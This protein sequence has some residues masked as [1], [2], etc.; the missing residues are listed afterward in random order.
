M[1]N[2]R[3]ASS[4]VEL[5]RSRAGE[6][7]A[8][9]AYTFLLNGEEE[10]GHATYGEL[11]RRARSIAARLQAHSAPGA[12]ALL[13]YP[14]GLEYIAALFGCFYAGVTAVPAYPP[15][16]NRA[17]ARLQSIVADCRPTL[18]LTTRELLGD[19]ERLC[20]HTPELAGLR[21]VATED[22]PAEEAEGWRD[23]EARGDTLAFLQ[24]TSGSTAAPKG[25]MVSHGNLLHNF[26][27][28]EE[29]CG[30]TPQTRSVIW[31]PPYHDMGLIGGILQPLFTG[32]WAALFSPVAFIQRPAR[33][34]EAVSRYR[35]T[36]SGGPNFAY[37]LCV[38]AVGPEERAGLDLSHWEIAFNGA[39][40][41][42][43]ET[44]R[45]FAESFAPCGFRE[46]AFYP[47]YGLAEATLMVT[48]SRP[49][50]P[51][52]QRAVEPEAL[53]EGLVRAA[54]EE[55]S[56]RLVGSGRSAPSQRV[57][58]VDPATLR[59]CPSER[60][61]EVWVAGPSVAR[62]YWGRPE[63]TA[64]TF[65]A[66]EAGTGEGP[67][68]RTGDL[69][70]LDGG[71]LYITGRLKD[72]IVIRGRNHYPQDIEQTALRSHEG[73]RAGSGAAF[74]I[75]EGG[76]ERLVVVQEVTRRAARLDVEEVA[77]AIRR[78][79]AAEHGLQ[80]H[81]VAVVRPGGVPKT[82]SGKVQRRA[83]RALF[84]AGDLPLVGV[85]V[86]EETGREAPRPVRA[87]LTREALEAAEVGERQALLE[88][89]L[90]ER[91]AQ[92][93]GVDPARVDREQPLVAL[94][95]DSLRAMEL[96]GALEAS[97][98]AQVPVSSLLD[99]T[100][101]DRLAAELLQ[102][103]FLADAA[104]PASGAAAG[105]ER[106]LSFAQERL[107][108]LDRLR[109]GATYNISL[110]VRVSGA[111]DPDV[112]GRVLGEIVR[113]HESLRTVFASVDGRPVQVVRP[114]GEWALAV[115]DVSGLPA[116]ERE[117]A[118]RRIAEAEAGAPFDL[119]AGPLLRTR[120]VRLAEDD[121]LL[122]VVMHHTVSDGGSVAVL[123]R[124][125]AA[126]YPALLAGRG[127]PLPPLPVQYGDWALRQR[128]RVRGAAL[129][130][131]LAYWRER[132]RG[133][134]PLP[135]P[136]DHPR[137]AVQSFR[138]AT[139]RFEIPAEVMEG[140]RALARAEGA[141]LFMALL[142][143]W[144]LV[145]ARYSGESDVAVGT[146]VSGRDR[147]E[148]AGLV[149]MFVDTLVLRVEVAPEEG[150]RELLA[151]ARAAALEGFRHRDLPFERLVEDLHP[152]RDLSR[153]PLF[154]VMLAP[155]STPLEPV[156]IPGGSL[157]PEPL[158]GGAA[159]LDLTLFTWERRG[160][161]L[162]AALEYATDLFESGTIERMAGHLVQVL[163][164]VAAA[165]ELAVAEV[166]LL[167]PAER[168]QLLARPPR[169]EHPREAVH[170][171]VAAQAARTPD[172]VAVAFGGET[173]TYAELERRAN[174]LANHL[175]R[176]GVRAEDRVGIC[177]ERSLDLPVAMLAV[178]RAGAAY[179]PLDPGYPA[180]RL[181]LMLEDSGVRVLLTQP[182]LQDRLPAHAAVSVLL[183][184]ARARIAEE[185]AEA[186][187]VESD[188]DRLAYVIYTSGS[189]G[190]PK[191]V[192]VPHRA[193]ANHMGWMQRAFPLAADD[194]VLQKTP[195]G[196]D[197]SVW[198]F[199]APLLAGATLV[200]APP[201]A[202]R[203]PAELA[204]VVERERITVLQVV[205]SLL[206]AMLEAGGLERCGTLRRLFCGGEALPVEMAARAAE[207]TGAEV[208]NLYGPTEVCIDAIFHVF[209]RGEAG[210]TVPIGRPVDNASARVLDPRGAPVP[211]GVPGELY[212]GGAQL[213]R[214]Y[215]G[216]AGLTAGTFVPD[217]FA[218]ADEPGA[219]AYR[220]GDRVRWRADG[221]LE[222]LGRVDEQ[223]KVRGFRIEPGEVEAALRAYP[224]VG[225][226][227]VAGRPDGGGGTR[228]VAYYLP[229]EGVA[230]P[231]A[232]EL[233]AWLRER[234]PESM[235]PGA[236]VALE[237]LPLTPSGKVDRRALPEPEAVNAWAAEPVPPSTAAEEILA[238][239]WAELLH[240]AEVGVHDDFFAL[241]G[242]SLLST[243]VISRVR[244]ALGV[245]L[246]LRILFEEPTI[247]GLAGHIEALLGDGVGA[248]PP[249]ER[250][251]RE[252]PLPLSFAQQRL[253]VVDRLE[254]GSAAYNMAGA[255]RLRG[256][257]DLAAL[258]SGIGGLTRRHESLRTTF[259]ERGGAPVQVIHPPTPV[260]LPL[261]DLQ[262][263][264]EAQREPE[265]ERLAAEEALRPFDLARGPLLRATLVRLADDDHVLLFTLHHVVSDGW[266]TRVLVREI[267]A[268]YAAFSGGEEPRLAE[269]PIQYADYAVWQRE[270]LSGEV[271]EE[272]IGYWKSS[273]AG[274][275]PL[276]EIPTD[277][278]R[279]AGQSA[280]AR[281]HRF[282]LSAEVSR[283]LRAVSRQEGT[284]L[285]MTVLAGWTELLGR[286]AGQEDVVVGT[287]IAGRTRQ[288]TEG[289]IGFFV[290]MLA[291]RADLSGDP[292][293]KEL[294]GRVREGT[295]GAY[296]H[297]EL[298]FERLI[299]ELSVERSLTHSPLFQATFA[300][301]QAGGGEQGL[302]LG[303]LALEPFGGGAQ[304]AKF[305]LELTLVDAEA[306]LGGVLLYRTAL[307][308]AETIARL[309]GHLET[310][311]E[312]IAADPGRRSSEVSLLRGA[313]R[314]Q[315]LEGWN[316]T[317]VEYPRTCLHDLVS[318]QAALTPRAVAVVFEGQSLTY[319]ELESRANRLAHHLRHLGV[320]PES[321]V[322]VCA[323]RSPELIVALLGVLK[324]GG[325]YVPLDP[326][327][328]AERLAYVLEDSGAALVVAQAHSAER[329]PAGVPR[330]LLDAQA[331]R[332]AARPDTVL[333][334]AAGPG[335]LAYVIY[336][337]G[338]TGR[339]K[340]V[341]VE[342]RSASQVVHFL[343][344]VVRPE[345]RAVVLG[346][347][348]VSFDVSVAEIFATLC[349]GGTL[350]LVE[351]V[352][353]LP[354]VAD[355]GVRLV[356]AVPSALAELLRDGGIP[357]SVR[358][359]N[360]A[361]EALP[362]W[363]ARELYA[364]PHV[365]RVLNLYGPTEDTVYST[366][367]EVERGAAR[368]RIG[369]PVANSRAYVLDPGGSPVPVGVAGELCL[370]G[371][372]NARGYQG[373]PELT[374]E[375]FVPDPFSPEPG[376]RMYRTG[377]RARWLAEGEVE[378]LGRIDQQV[379]VRGFRVEPGEVEA[380]LLGHGGVREAVVTAR[381]DG[382]GG[383]R[384]VAYVVPAAGEEVGAAELRE[385]L[386]ERLPEH[387]VPGAFVTLERLPLNANG[388]V[389][390]RALPAPEHG[391][392]TEYV[393]PRT[394][395][396]EVLSGIWAEVLGVERVGAEDNFFERGGHSLLATQVVARVRQAFGIE[397]PL[398]TLFEAPTVAALVG[399]IDVLRGAGSLQAPPIERVPRTEPLPLSFAQQRLWLVD[400]LEPGS[401]AYNMAGALRLRG[402]LDLA[403][404][405][406]SLDA[407]VERHE[408]LRTTFAEGEG[409]VPV[410]VIHPPAPVPLPPVDLRGLPEAEREP[411]AERLAAE[412]ALRPFDLE[413][414]PLLRAT[415]V[416][417][418]E[419]DHV[420]TITLH[421]VVGDGWSMGVLLRE[422]SALYAALGHGRKPRLPDLPVQ[423]AD[424]AVWQRAW[425]SGEVLE[426]QIG[427]WKERLRG[428]P[429]L[430]EIPTDRPRGVGQSPRAA[431]HPFRLPAGL[432]RGLRELSRGEGTT[433]FMTLLAGWQ[434]LLGRYA[435]QDDVVVGTPVAGRSRREVEGL[436]GF[437][438]NMLA[439]R[440]D[441][442][443]NPTWRELLGQVREAAL[444][445]YE[446]QEL[447]FERLVEALEV[448][449]SLTLTPVFQ[450][451]FAL[452]RSAALDGLA[453][454]GLAVEPLGGSAGV[455]K[456]DLGL[457]F[458]DGGDALAGA[459]D[460][461]AALFE[462]ETIAR[463]A[464]H[465]EVLL[466]AMTAGPARRLREVPL[467]RD[468]ERTQVLETWNA[469]AAPYP[470]A[471]V[472]DLVTAQAARTPG[473]AAVVFAGELLSYAGLER[474]GNRL[475][476]HLRRLGVGPETRVGVCL[477]RTPELV[478]ALLG[479]LKAGGAYVPLDPTYPRERLGSMQEDAGVSLVLT[480]SALEGVL[481]GGTR[482]LALD[483][484]RAAIEAESEAEPESGVLPE[485]LSHVI[486]TSGSTGRPKG[487]MIR[488]SSTVVL[489][490]WLRETVSDE[491]RASVLFSTSINFDVSVAEVF[492]TLAW[493]GKLV[494]V[495][496]AL[497]LASLEE[498][499]AY[500][501]MVPTAAAELLRMGRVPASLR[502]LNLG[503]EPLSNDLAQALYAQGT[504]ETVGNL[505]GPT[506]DTTYSTYSRVPRG[507]DRVRVGGPVANTQALVLDAWLQPVPVGVVGELYLAGDGLS[508][509]YVGRPEL[510]A[511]R[512]LPNPF[513]APGSRMYRVMDRIRWVAGGSWSTWGGRTSRSRCGASASSWGRSSRRCGRAPPRARRWP[514]CART[515]RA[516]GGSWRTWSR[517][518]APP[519]TRR[520]CGRTS[521][522]VSRSTCSPRRSSR[523]RRCRS[524]P[525]GSWTGG[526]SAPRR[527]PTPGRARSRRRGR[528]PRS[529][530]PGSS[531]RFWAR[532]RWG[533]TPTSSSWAATRCWRPA[534]RRGRGRRSG[535]TCRCARSSRRPRWPR[536]R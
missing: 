240:L 278:S 480:S 431:S 238:G 474:R 329:L 133:V 280:R 422:T 472:H 334:A 459:L 226:A 191:G 157:V 89:L 149:G 536:S 231:S 135:L 136:T 287:P 504:I 198:E 112:L 442:S 369:R 88:E 125:V 85:S 483:A 397:L 94:G 315:V 484:A 294:L 387:M 427:F 104:A 416:R 392:G 350:V 55:G 251:S 223:V 44:L 353:E 118:A 63:E 121:H 12:R 342:H 301:E 531:R 440:A 46:S 434:A 293:W 126:L 249:I 23:P 178:L 17:D 417:L 405:R 26:A 377:D 470:R 190:T 32:Y 202:H 357:E 323:E 50:E 316:A 347:T 129:E 338:S 194:R 83:C 381:E 6:D 221:T 229:A 91:A 207:A 163:R 208:V 295:L 305:E 92:V 7:P 447:P 64:E 308:E 90:V 281:S 95:M 394:L 399:R 204:R 164:A 127:S 72:L 246:P 111:L 495:E 86:R 487:V 105:G 341:M 508:R 27:L 320:G 415:L 317:S 430:L 52:V 348:S 349:W 166:P 171:Q 454:G 51:P 68:L 210:A 43:H 475:A 67:F 156:E 310:V 276:L 268:L 250:A 379:K 230:P 325:A 265:A 28:I 501:S 488:H 413:R 62:G 290:N 211:V 75:E 162:A 264:P 113:R 213:A 532:G 78:A 297:Q 1:P 452:E 471:C 494:L 486:F 69:G 388:K 150:F 161:A 282:A 266:S 25:V 477:E 263:L 212:L 533:R 378:Y 74:S 48:G 11:D 331:E 433:L 252:E 298:P 53:G 97:L 498:P 103:V 525:A 509:G 35:A 45:A 14:P 114:A 466:E 400:R 326:A 318:A 84:L 180:A 160:G 168:A 131:Q 340:G 196:F 139:H 409:G 100:R 176:L 418:G 311:L 15:R 390:R 259:E 189:T 141:T 270:W 193:L 444:G 443:G 365:E 419:A 299:D 60:V 500:A 461:R 206:G 425:F 473:A 479:V 503:G 184:A 58:I 337:S 371:A 448:E 33:W 437:F 71:E 449:R 330:V 22:V 457:T 30:Y 385:H 134:A 173:L 101:I 70:F 76:E 158:D 47:C 404:L 522:S 36:S 31:L 10:E 516:S 165:P 507:G 87:G 491:E 218:D 216:K 247:A 403:A 497:E 227:A 345:H 159:A 273:L 243:Q 352:L 481:P 272:Q 526:P 467:L 77:A 13:L 56:Y 117:A 306:E 468:S 16:R 130:E 96:K 222:F 209:A 244:D 361:G 255:L 398:R 73:L 521:A 155:Q 523:C 93:L 102:E 20:A 187:A 519:S 389:D 476:N 42:R 435:A 453:L 177:L 99:D 456:F 235:V 455:A 192:A 61:G 412:E 65:A 421:H 205:P 518:T 506:E 277:H 2:P 143:A 356:V 232:A 106:P 333:P 469:T 182:A 186:P 438:V 374:G 513:G 228:L 242:H 517:P 258:R 140:V 367:S 383:R 439:L 214:G 37:E 175:R 201:D 233:R 372:G 195:A 451:T 426:G 401:A 217:A 185:S 132:L 79:V 393:A 80:V 482:T 436:V 179:V 411:E 19:A 142:A 354:R 382:P 368:V 124:E 527:R 169:R 234:L 355:A 360:L 254:P 283:G 24:Y 174:R 241:G 271:L 81:A 183:D 199:W 248:A 322:G 239:I 107:W 463:L 512:Y 396:E 29:F 309:M 261:V 408:T 490:H 492:G 9:R 256:V 366:W 358:A 465:L 153:N 284:T 302:R 535:W 496:N 402:V 511:E 380:A 260:P 410:Q 362:A 49:A 137:P 5:L 59:E 441:L 314:V 524:P 485:N 336:T 34:L 530:W 4:L 188:G 344:D 359:F 304:F 109:P 120:L 335:N 376:G 146:S 172:A 373:R 534:P 502:T 324:A 289:L 3:R 307:F 515:R 529:C 514:W 21:W 420:L 450:V 286:W 181:A 269:L 445:A 148:V 351:N 300:L 220:T 224:G 520:R 57:L 66:Y 151:R 493:G 458:R 296:E 328:P 414:G 274:A 321:R 432:S 346:S 386:R 446:H 110:A 145:L 464:G 363:L 375:K 219:R 429:P 395:T 428:S 319:A 144:D 82:S 98:G 262:G 54:A 225:G 339:P 200:M 245:E 460:H 303:G 267:S 384:L 215:L 288:E 197:A 152:G 291:L 122:A 343:R 364:L 292:T 116:A 391:A 236:F 489:L 312:A 505:Y 38:H 478:V 275:P 499:V 407:L 257:L 423:Y 147:A 285:F 41:V 528:R 128:E 237:A 8:R 313:E 253:W 370:G 115:D 108:F 203:D 462:A 167:L 406:A 18:A 39:E 332:I 170:A 40:P 279:V 327:Y 138:G 510:T 424:Y 123:L 154:Q 119:A